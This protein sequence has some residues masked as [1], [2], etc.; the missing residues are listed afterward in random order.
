MYWLGVIVLLTGVSLNL[1]RGQFKVEPNFHGNVADILPKPGEIP[2]WEVVYA[3][4]A[5]TPEMKAKVKELLNYDQGIFAIYRHGDLRVSVYLAY[6]KP[7]NMPVRSIARHTPDVC[8]VESGWSRVHREELVNLLVGDRVSP[9]AEY[10]VYSIAG[11]TEHVTFWH[12]AGGEV[13]SY[14]TGARPPWHAAITE[15]F[16]WGNAIKQEQFFLRISCNQPPDQFCETKIV[17]HVIDRVPGILSP[18]N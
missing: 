7:G 16:R 13:I 3:P 14:H 2:G 8:W 4:I 12:V 15:F 18:A 11:V 10:G 1:R 9:H 17:Q 6:W 5:E